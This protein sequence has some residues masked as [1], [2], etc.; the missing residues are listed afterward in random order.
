MLAMLCAGDRLAKSLGRRANDWLFTCVMMPGHAHHE[1]ES[2]FYRTRALLT[3]RQFRSN[4]GKTS[5]T[6]YGSKDRMLRSA[7]SSPRASRKNASPATATNMQPWFHPTRTP[8]KVTRPDAACMSCSRSM[9]PV[10][11]KVLASSTA[12]EAMAP[13]TTLPEVGA[14]NT[15]VLCPE[16]WVVRS[17]CQ[18]TGRQG[19]AV[20]AHLDWLVVCQMMRKSCTMFK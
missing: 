11:Y 4:A 17:R 20:A 19:V 13:Y 3:H 16:F 12:T 2:K 15:W 6:S 5:R 18:I 7:R 10:V 8:A 9:E 14:V 1:A